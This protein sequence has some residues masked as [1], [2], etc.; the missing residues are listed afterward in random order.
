MIIM[1]ISVA[2]FFQMISQIINCLGEIICGIKNNYYK[3]FGKC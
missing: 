2:D 3:E 1:K